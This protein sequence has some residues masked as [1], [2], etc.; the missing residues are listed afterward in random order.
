MCE[1]ICCTDTSL[2][3]FYTEL[4]NEIYESEIQN[5]FIDYNY[6]RLNKKNKLYKAIE[7]YTNGTIF[8]SNFLTD[9]PGFNIKR[10][11]EIK[12]G[13]NYRKSNYCKCSYPDGTYHL[14]FTVYFETNSSHSLTP[15]LLQKL[16]LI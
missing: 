10:L 3:D 2:K 12:L 7:S 8:Y 6:P 1:Y 15:P 11:G 14:K 16:K 13:E 9:N 5:S 4:Y